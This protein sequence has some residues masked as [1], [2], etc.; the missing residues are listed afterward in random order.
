LTQ[1][2]AIERYVAPPASATELAL[3]ALVEQLRESEARFREARDTL[4][5]LNTELEQRVAARTADLQRSNEDLEQF[6]YAVSHD[7]QAPLR[8]ISGFIGL[9]E[10]RYRERLDAEGQELLRYVVDGAQRM[11]G[12]IGDILLY[13]RAGRQA[14][15]P[16]PVDMTHALAEALKNLHGAIEES[17]AQHW[18]FSVGDNGIGI[19]RDA[20]YRLFR[21]FQRL[22]A[23]DRYTGSGVG[24]ALCKRI[25]ES[26]GGRIWFDSEPCRG[27]TFHFAWPRTDA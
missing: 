1:I 22:H 26:H 15:V 16:A 19:P 8:T 27:S 7:L 2:F 4:Q 23:D 25:V 3:R 5:R 17:G 14:P 13:A 9:L 18:H 21:L 11:H 20:R 24:L 12:M 6:T 10:K